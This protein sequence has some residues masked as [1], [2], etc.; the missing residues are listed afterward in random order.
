MLLQNFYNNVVDFI[1][2]NKQ[3]LQQYKQDIYKAGGWQHFDLRLAFDCFYIHRRQATIQ[4]RQQGQQDFDFM[5]QIATICNIDDKNKILDNHIATL[6][7][8]AI[9]DCGLL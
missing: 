8:K 9:K 1:N 7:K 2:D 6:Y 5:Q 4:A 3:F